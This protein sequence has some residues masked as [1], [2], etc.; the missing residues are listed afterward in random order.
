M[1]RKLF[2][3]LLSPVVLSC[4][5]CKQDAQ[6]KDLGPVDVIVISGQSN[7]VGCSSSAGIKTAFSISKYNEFEAGYDEIKISYD[8][9]TKDGF[10]TGRYSYFSQNSSN[11]KFVPVKLGQ[12]NNTDNFGPEIGIAEALHEKYANKLFI[13]KFACGASNLRDDWTQRDSEMYPRLVKYVNKAIGKLTKQGYKPTIKA[14]CWMQGE[15]DTYSATYHAHYKENLITFVGHVREDFAKY[16][17]DREITFVD[18]KICPGQ[19][20]FWAEV[21]IAK[22]QFSE[23]SDNN[24]LIDSIQ[25]GLTLGSDNAHFDSRS[26]VELGHLFADNFEPF[27]METEEVE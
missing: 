10:D 22:R 4:V 13:I 8:C 15:G 24:L 11:N 26:Q 19:W 1:K 23:M 18:A 12:G 7:A 17:G 25:E 3:L 5:S 2:M 20:T 16:A 6:T 27:L 21:N 9:W 14:F